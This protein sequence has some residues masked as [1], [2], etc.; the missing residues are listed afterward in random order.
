MGRAYK[1][2]QFMVMIGVR[3][4]LENQRV[5]ISGFSELLFGSA[6]VGDEE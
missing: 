4:S 1:G 3:E 2:T 5:L 6:L